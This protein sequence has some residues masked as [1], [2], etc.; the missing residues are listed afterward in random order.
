MTDIET[1]MSVQLDRASIQ[2]AV[3]EASVRA[4]IGGS[5]ELTITEDVKNIQKRL[6]ILTEKSNIDLS[7]FIMH[8]GDV[9][10]PS[11]PPTI[12]PI[13]T[14]Y[15]T[16]NNGVPVGG[17][18]SIELHSDGTCLFS[19]HFHDSGAPSYNVEFVWVFVDS[20]G[21][22][23]TFSASGHMNGTFESGSRDYN[24][25]NS[26]NS[27]DVRNNWAKLVAGYRWKWNAHVGW[28][29]QAAVDAAV[30]ALKAAGAV[31]G[32]VVAIVALV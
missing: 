15:I 30:N 28:D 19:G 7:K 10:Q 16:F 12:G 3:R 1:P 6:P 21:V 31:I 9:D 29:V 13:Q 22:A 2:D 24:W 4:T 18:A 23:Y 11:L 26:T 27:P 20:G 5:G 32:A 8:L 17:Y 25:T 14:G